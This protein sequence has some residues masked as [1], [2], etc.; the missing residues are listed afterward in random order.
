[1]FPAG[2]VARALYCHSMPNRC[3]PAAVVAFA[4][5]I[6]LGAP[7]PAR[8]DEAQARAL[9]HFQKGRKLYQVS[10]Y[11][12][13]LEEFKR[14]F[15][16][17]EDPVFLFNIGQCHRQLGDRE[18]AITFYRRYVAAAPAAE[19]RPQVENLIRE[20]QGA[21]AAPP[22]RQE[23]PP[24]GAALPPRLSLAPAPPP[25]RTDREEPSVFRRWWFWTLVGAAVVAGGGAYLLWPRQP[26]DPVC[27]SG[28][29][30]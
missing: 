5:V 10:D 14:A 3:R 7:G 11:R 24:P 29:K 6:A 22:P 20:L 23:P 27:P 18:E 13:A 9:E 2:R 21:P 12:A 1:M 19:N 26:A 16:I 28:V 15:L 25:D 30:C 4:A 8:A 17:K